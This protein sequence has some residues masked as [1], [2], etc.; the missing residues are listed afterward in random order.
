MSTSEQ[1]QCS[2][3]CM[4]SHMFCRH[5]PPPPATPP[6]LALP[7]ALAAFGPPEFLQRWADTMR[8]HGVTVQT[9]PDGITDLDAVELAVVFDPPPGLLAR[10]PNLR[11]VHSMGAG[12]SPGMLDNAVCPAHLPLLRVA[13]PLMAQRMSGFVHW[14]VLN[15]QRRW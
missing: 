1:Q 2:L 6:R 11:A 13:D 14:A 9:W 8:A 3:K 10:C 4:Q 15:A 5:P 12:V 7:S